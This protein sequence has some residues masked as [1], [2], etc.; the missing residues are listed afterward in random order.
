MVYE[1]GRSKMNNQ[2]RRKLKKVIDLAD[3]IMALM[4]DIKAEEEDAYDNLPESIQNSERGE[5][6]QQA[7]D[8]MD[9][10]MG[11]LDTSY[12]EELL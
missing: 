9:E 2:R 6:M 4:E 5:T 10:F 3:D 12:L 1:R 11:N 7:I 8:T